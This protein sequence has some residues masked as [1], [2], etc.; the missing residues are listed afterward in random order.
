[1]H[2]SDLQIRGVFFSFLTTVFS[3][4]SPCL[5]AASLI[6]RPEKCFYAGWLIDNHTDGDC[7]PEYQ[8]KRVRSPLNGSTLVIEI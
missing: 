3:Q 1:M 4:S 6:P 8:E 2:R 7:K 5:P